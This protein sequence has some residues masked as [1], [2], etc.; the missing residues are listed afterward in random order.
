MAGRQGWGEGA[1][2]LVELFGGGPPPRIPVRG[3]VFGAALV[4][5]VLLAVSAV[6]SVQPHEAAVV[7]RFGAYHATYG[8]GL[9][10]RIPVV[11]RVYKV[12]VQQQLKE[13]FG[14]RTVRAGV[15]TQYS[16]RDYSEEALMLTGDLNVADVEWI[17]QYR[18]QDPRSFLFHVREPVQT[19]RDLNEAVVRQ[20]V[21]DHS[22]DEVLTV[23]REAI[24][25]EAKQKLQDLCDRYELGLH[26]E[27]LVLQDVNPPDPVKPSFNEVN[28]ALQEKER[29]INEAWAE[30]NRVVPRAR[31]EAAQQIEMAE[32]YALE[33]VNNAR[34]DA[35][36]FLAL[37]GEYRKAPEVTR[38]R[39][40][41]ET[42]R[43]VL[44]KV[45][46]KI[47]ADEDL[48]GLLPLLHLDS[49]GPAA[50]GEKK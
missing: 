4:A 18:I 39:I 27:Q 24:A 12:P 31:G 50:R 34:G 26:I 33:R 7:L 46:L 42:A 8:P 1:D 28:Q 30:Y 2:R 49:D 44:A 19:L 43:E 11:D 6:Y 21:G 22:V 15:R 3:I 45:G 35:A 5:G 48:T 40:Y 9:H 32:G 16:R 14:F 37:Y 17:V 36:R 10:F 25:A 23:G 29:L 20:I 13:E 47:V 41:L 38:R